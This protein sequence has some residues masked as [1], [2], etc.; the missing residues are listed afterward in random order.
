[1][2]KLA[3]LFDYK[4]VYF[5]LT[6]IILSIMTKKTFVFL[7]SALLFTQSC[8]TIFNGGSQSVIAGASGDK[9][10]IAIN[11]RTPRGSY[12]SKLPTTVV[13]TPSSFK[14]TTVTV[15]EKCYER[16]EMIVGKSVTPSFWEQLFQLQW[17]LII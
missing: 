8:S 6:T 13:T 5:D 12:R 10:N 15:N 16:T 4:E 9:D 2:A 14:D 17:E 3:L 1:M 11:V 7:F